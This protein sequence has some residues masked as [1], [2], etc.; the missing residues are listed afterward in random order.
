MMSQEEYRNRCRLSLEFIANH[1][2]KNAYENDG[3]RCFYGVALHQQHP[4]DPHHHRCGTRPRSLHIAVVL[5]GC[6]A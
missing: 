6:N 5:S 2:K 4:L 3:S 1:A